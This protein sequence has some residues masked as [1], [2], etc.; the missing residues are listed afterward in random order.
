MYTIMV[1]YHFDYSDSLYILVMC[2]PP[3]EYYR[4]QQETVLLTV[5]NSHSQV[6]FSRFNGTVLSYYIVAQIP[7]AG[8]A[9]VRCPQRLSLLLKD[10]YNAALRQ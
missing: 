6:P 1:H 2:S 8:L 4:H 3:P 7:K 5:Q 9:F 10:H